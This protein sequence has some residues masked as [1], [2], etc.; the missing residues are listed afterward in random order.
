[1]AIVNLGQ[2]REPHESSASEALR[3][4]KT[5]MDMFSQ[6][7]AA[8]TNAKNAGTAATNAATSAQNATTREGELAQSIAS[9]EI[10]KKKM[11]IDNVKKNY[12]LFSFQWNS[13]D[14]Q[15]QKIYQTSEPYKEL[16]K[17]FK[18]FKDI[19]PGMIDEQGNIVAAASKTIYADQLKENVAQ[20]KM[21]VAA[22]TGTKEQ[23]NMIRLDKLGG[24]DAM[25]TALDGL[26]KAITAGD[27]DKG[28][29]NAAMQFIT[30]WWDKF[31]Q[32]R[33]ANKA[34]DAGVPVGVNPNTNALADPLGAYSNR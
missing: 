17:F 26:E 3:T 18:G 10:T 11:D 31:Q 16:Q 33:E 23:I 25:A 28:D 21:S 27:I 12:D 19:A 14:D 4:M 9:S 30:S 6:V 24:T 22:G 13:M 8:G 1:M 15:Q 2:L 32:K 5:G 29:K 20:A 7:S 34:I